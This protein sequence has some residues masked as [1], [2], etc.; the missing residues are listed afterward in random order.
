M[1]YH[2]VVHDSRGVLVSLSPARWS[3]VMPKGGALRIKKA[4]VARE[5]ALSFTGAYVLRHVRLHKFEP[6]DLT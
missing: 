4:H 2:I 5:V 1:A 6:L 3:T